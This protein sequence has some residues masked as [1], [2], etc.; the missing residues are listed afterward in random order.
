[1]GAMKGARLRRRKPRTGATFACVAFVLFGLVA[2]HGWGTHAGMHT[3]TSRSPAH[4][5]P[6]E[7]DALASVLTTSHGGEPPRDAAALG[8]D[9]ASCD[10]GCGAPG[11]DGGMGLVALCLAILGG[12][13]LA[14]ALL[15]LRRCVPLL[16][17]M[18]SAFHHLV[19]LS[20][21]RDP[22]DLLRLCVNRC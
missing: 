17:T 16:R 20:R 2:M 15:L 13:V 6:L 5:T 12:L 1:M 14:F 9:L 8:A 10:D 19:P 3:P 21:D 22:P 18:L 7:G 4:V 11:S